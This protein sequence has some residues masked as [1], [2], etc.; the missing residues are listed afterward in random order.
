MPIRAG[1]QVNVIMSNSTKFLVVISLATNFRCRIGKTKE[2]I[3]PTMKT[4]KA[5]LGMVISASQSKGWNK[6]R[7]VGG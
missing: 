1:A 4:D 6:I 2:K 3:S 5:T 7:E